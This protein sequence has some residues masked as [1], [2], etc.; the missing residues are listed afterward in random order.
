[1][2]LPL[3]RQREEL[4]ASGRAIVAAGARDLLFFR[5]D[6]DAPVQ[7]GNVIARCAD[8]ARP[9]VWVPMNAGRD[10]T[11]V[12]RLDTCAPGDPEDQLVVRV[13]GTPAATFRVR[14]DADRF[15]SYTVRVPGGRVRSSLNRVDLAT[16]SGSP[17]V[18]L[19]Y[20]QVITER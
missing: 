8:T 19:W 5:R 12:L 16:D 10:A 11:L 3:A 14:H 18:R 13:N 7:S 15:G 1:M 6:W 2:A 17:H 20:V 4:R 9:A